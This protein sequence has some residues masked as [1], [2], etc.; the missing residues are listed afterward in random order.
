MNVEQVK[1]RR[2]RKLI[3][4]TEIK[5]MIAMRKA[6]ITVAKIAAETGRAMSS[7]WRVLQVAK[8][9]NKENVI[10]YNILFDAP[11]AMK[12]LTQEKEAG[13]LQRMA[14]SFCKFLGVTGDMYGRN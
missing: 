5:R 12:P 6:G 10:P 7:V 2:K 9:D 3:K 14:I 1:P 13:W 11:A 8:K 4:K